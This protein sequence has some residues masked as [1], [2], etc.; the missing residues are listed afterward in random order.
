MG[1][2][3]I[4]MVL[5]DLVQKPTIPNYPRLLFF[6]T[7]GAVSNVSDVVEFIA[8]HTHSMRIYSIGIGNG[9]S[10]ELIQGC[11][12]KGKG[13]YTFITDDEKPEQK[14]INLLEKALSPVICDLQLQY[15]EQK[16]ESIVPNPKK[17]PFI[18]KDDLANFYF[19]FKGKLTEVFKIKITYRDSTNKNYEETIKIDPNGKREEKW[20]HCLISYQKIR[21]LC[22]TLQFSESE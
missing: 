18:L 3:E 11:A 13:T 5:H 2:T 6:L 8:K 17:L 1:G 21:A 4:L 16:V 9:C 20:L 22:D 15:D 19:T 14:I 7:D 10:E 12:E